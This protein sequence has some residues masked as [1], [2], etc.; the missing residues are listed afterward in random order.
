MDVNVQKTLLFLLFI[1]LGLLLKL[2]IKEKKE[3]AGIKMIILNLALPATIFIALLSVNVEVSLLVLP[4]IA[5]VLNFFLF[6]VTP[7]LFPFIGIKKDSP[8]YRTA[9]MLIPSLA[10][11]LSCFP[12]ILEY[13]GEGFLAKAA[14]A[15]LGNKLFVLLIL[16]L[17]AMNWHYKTQ[18]IT[19][20]S[21]GAKF[22]S[23]CMAMVSEPVNLFI[24]AALILLFL[25]INMNSIPFLFSESLSRLSLLM[26][27]LVLLFIGLSVNIKKRQFAEIISLLL[28]RAG[29]VVFLAIGLIVFADIGI[30]EDRLLLLAF[31]LSACSFWPFT[32]IAAV[33]AQEKRVL[34][35][36]KTFNQN[37]AINILAL[38]FP[39][40]V[41]L[42]LGILSAGNQIA[43][44][45]TLVI[46]ALGLLGCGLI[47]PLFTKF[48]QKKNTEELP[49][50]TEAEQ[51]Y[52]LKRVSEN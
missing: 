16:Y 50:V 41:V 39:L 21:T 7:F 27:P 14:M 42:I 26:T 19:N 10:P 22:K 43:D 24:A 8:N 35:S 12:F 48:N 9:Q 17:V 3:L 33:D 1:G 52:N 5:L 32:H 18:N 15:D 49:N 40:S 6:L 46:L 29:I 20:R 13:L 2:K 31:G 45:Y 36:R 4:G 30:A 11:G 47:Y 44:L 28:V 34:N 23:L 25:G 51:L 38:S 37:F